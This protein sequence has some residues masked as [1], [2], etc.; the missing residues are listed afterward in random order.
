VIP[1]VGEEIPALVKAPIDRVQLVKYAGAS[2]DF[3]PIHTDHLFA[4]EAGLPSV[5]AHGMLAMAALGELLTGWAGTGSVRKMQVRFLAI[6]SPGDRLTCH[7]KVT[8]LDEQIIHLEIWAEKD[9]GTRTAAGTAEV[10]LRS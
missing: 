8:A 5:I 10:A 9:D 7:G 1:P 3:N 2:G 4:Q 6:T